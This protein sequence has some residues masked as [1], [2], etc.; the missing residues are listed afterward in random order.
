MPWLPPHRHVHRIHITPPEFGRWRWLG[1]SAG[2]QRVDWEVDQD[3]HGRCRWLDRALPTTAIGRIARCPPPPLLG[4]RWRRQGIAERPVVLAWR[5]GRVG[6]TPVR[7]RDSVGRSEAARRGGAQRRRMEDSG[8][9]GRGEEARS[10]DGRCGHLGP[11]PAAEAAG[12][13]ATPAPALA[14]KATSVAP[15]ARPHGEAGAAF[16][17]APAPTAEAAS[18]A[19]SGTGGRP[20]PAPQRRTDGI[21]QARP[22]GAAVRVASRLQLHGGDRRHSP[23]KAGRRGR[24]NPGKGSGGVPSPPLLCSSS[25]SHPQFSFSAAILCRDEL[26]SAHPYA[27]R[28]ICCLHDLLLLLHRIRHSRAQAFVH[29][30]EPSLHSPSVRGKLREGARV[31]RCGGGGHTATEWEADSLGGRRRSSSSEA[32]AAANSGR[33]PKWCG[34]GEGDRLQRIGRSTPWAGTGAAQRGGSAGRGG[35]AMGSRTRGR[36]G[37]WRGGERRGAGLEGGT[38]PRVGQP[39]AR[40]R[41]HRVRELANDLAAVADPHGPALPAAGRTGA[42]IGRRRRRPLGA[43]P[44]CPLG[45]VPPLPNA[46]LLLDPDGDFSFSDLNFPSLSDESPAASD[47]TP[48]R[49]PPQA[50]PAPPPHPPGGSHTRS[51]SPKAFSERSAGL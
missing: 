46:D 7:V 10:P 18:M 49:P 40:L 12:T 44:T 6:S 21:D 14:A 16:T 9:R 32:G 17:P 34:A 35:A 47:P 38:R 23:S 20:T 51:L 22:A 30:C 13:A 45:V 50:A 31:V 42:V 48:P 8:R 33:E 4:A 39:R 29:R 1:S 26:N 5:E 3:I 43:P 41:R 2:L 37:T 27:L 28:C 15:L 25:R 19:T 36:R 24:L 11:T